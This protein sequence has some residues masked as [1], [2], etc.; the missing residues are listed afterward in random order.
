MVVPVSKPK[1]QMTFRIPRYLQ[2]VG[3]KIGGRE[4]NSPAMEKRRKEWLIVKT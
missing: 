4:V 2:E 3:N 1:Q